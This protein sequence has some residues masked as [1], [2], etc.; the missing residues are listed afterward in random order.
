M[1]KIDRGSKTGAT[2]A[3]YT[4]ALDWCTTELAEKTILLENSGSS[5][6]LK[7]KMF[8]YAA[9]NGIAVE[10]IAENTLL[11]GEIV[12]M[13]YQRQWHRLVLQVTNG[14]GEADYQVDYEGQGA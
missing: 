1:W 12:Q 3:V 14:S 10:I 9:E 6:S 2:T 7:Y 11:P 4:D 5:A 8:G 13:H